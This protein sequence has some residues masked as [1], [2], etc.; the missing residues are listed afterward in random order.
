MI[1]KRAKVST[2]TVSRALNSYEYV[3]EKTRDRVWQIAR[4]LG[5]P[6]EKLRPIPEVTQSI[7]VVGMGQMGNP[8][9][10]PEFVTDVLNGVESVMSEKGIPVRSQSAP[11]QDIKTN[12][13]RYLKNNPG[14]MGFILLGGNMDY[15]FV[16]ELNA[17]AIPFVIAGGHPERVEATSIMGD[18]INGIAQAVTHLVERDRS[19]I[20]LL[21]TTAYTVTSN[22]KLKG[23]RLALSLHGLPFIPELVTESINSVEAGY[24]QMQHLL[25]AFPE[26]D[27]VICADDYVAVGALRT[28]QEQHI[29]VPHDVAVVGM[30]NY[31]VSA[32][33]N[34]PLTTIALDMVEMG[35][36][37]ALLLWTEMQEKSAL[38]WKVLGRTQLIIRQST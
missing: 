23:Y 17:A 16:N 24:E 20:G 18:Y 22:E 30:H 27:A 38:N 14:L 19:R 37:A 29:K 32:F 28:L 6:L 13:R 15:E 25:Q 1:A 8:P 21:N 34:P 11:L 7:L 10:T 12:I 26:I 2:S 3:D 31:S 35:K 5:Y 36:T 9:A 33:T 4:E